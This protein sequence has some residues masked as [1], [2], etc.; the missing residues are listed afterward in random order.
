MKVAKPTEYILGALT[1]Q[2]PKPSRQRFGVG[3]AWL[4]VIDPQVI[5]ADPTSAWAAP[6][7]D[8]AMA[9]ILKLADRFDDRVITTRWLPPNQPTGSWRAYLDRWSFANKPPEDALFDLV[10]DAVSL[11]RFPTIDLPTFSKWGPQ[12]SALVGPTP[13]LVLTGCATDC[14]IISTALAAADSGASV[15][16]V[17]DGCAG[18]SPENQASALHLMGLYDPQITVISSGDLGVR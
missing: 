18:S 9:V 4:V 6:G 8:D 10:P 3:P 7:F 13:N 5:F 11:S 17:D 16:V 2:K 12:L 1:R 14:C 15:R